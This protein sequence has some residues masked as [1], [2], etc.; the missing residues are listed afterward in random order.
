[1]ATRR[2]GPDDVAALAHLRWEW[3]V[4]ERGESGLSEVELLDAMTRWFG[5]HQESNLAWLAER[6]SKPV[7][8]AWL[9]IVPRLPSPAAPVRLAGNVQS[10]YVK[11][12]HRG[13]GL[14]AQ[15]IEA[16]VAESRQR[17]LEYMYL[18]SSEKAVPLYRRAGFQ[19]PRR[20]LEMDL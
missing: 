4:G 18:H 13:H 14:G 19:P 5:E 10:V 15:L 17:G 3:R 7:G 1:M 16:I 8:M 20:T 12:A 6:D 2:A 11:A 9:A